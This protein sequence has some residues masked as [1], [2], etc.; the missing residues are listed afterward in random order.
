MVLYDMVWSQHAVSEKGWRRRGAIFIG[1]GLALLIFVF[2]SIHL[3]V[4]G[5]LRLPL[6]IGSFLGGAWSLSS[7]DR[8]F[9]DHATAVPGT[10]AVDT[11]FDET[12]FRIS[13]GEASKRWNYEALQNV[14]VCSLGAY[15]FWTDGRLF[16]LPRED[17]VIGEP[18]EL[19]IFLKSKIR[20]CEGRR[21][22]VP[23]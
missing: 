19:G 4:I 7:W 12:G 11:E 1:T 6:L 5:F 14:A 15:L 23:L 3:F 17:F 10:V 21:G 13:K 18:E 8:N 16:A 20:E 9:Y 22:S 2:G